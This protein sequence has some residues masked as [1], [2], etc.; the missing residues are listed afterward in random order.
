M[1][2]IV[3][4]IFIDF[5]HTP[6]GGRP[7]S[8]KKRYFDGMC[9]HKHSLLQ[10]IIYFS[11]ESLINEFDEYLRKKTSDEEYQR[12]KLKYYDL[13]SYKFNEKIFALREKNPKLIPQDRSPQ[14]CYS[15][16]DLVQLETKDSDYIFWCD[17]GL[18][19]IVNFPSDILNNN[20]YIMSDMFFQDII[21]H[22][23]D[24]M[25]VVCGDRKRGFPGRLI[26]NSMGGNHHIRPVGGFW[27]GSASCV[28]PILYEYQIIIE[29]L[30]N[31]S[32][33]YLE[34]QVMEIHMKQNE[35]L[36]SPSI[37]DTWYH[38]ESK[39]AKVGDLKS[40]YKVFI[41]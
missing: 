6:F 16:F 40:L 39:S 17:A 29:K 32:L 7:K 9:R 33:L 20:S 27:G 10:K 22:I 36:Y 5:N 38:E 41:K 26:D 11:T 34:E 8:W 28:L 13:Y 12:Y 37:F 23:K 31:R 30:L 24:K 14:I 18:L 1:N 21:S 19:D 25:H 15:K 3:S 35:S 4:S 2:K